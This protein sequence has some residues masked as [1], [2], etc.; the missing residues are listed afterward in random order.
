MRKQLIFAELKKAEYHK[1]EVLIKELSKCE[2]LF[3]IEKGLARACYFKQDK[4]ITDWFGLENSV[5]AEV[6]T[7]MSF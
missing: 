5:I 2:R 1:G 7:S 4:E 3:F 6:V